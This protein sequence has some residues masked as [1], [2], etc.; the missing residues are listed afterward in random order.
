MENYL[1]IDGK[2]IEL[3][4][5]TADNIRSALKEPKSISFIPKVGIWIIGQDGGVDY[6]LEHPCR[7][8]RLADDNDGGFYFDDNGREEY[9]CTGVRSAT[10][11]E[12]ESHLKPICEEKY[13]GK[14]T[15]SVCDGHDAYPVKFGK[16]CINNDSLYYFD[17]DD[18]AIYVYH[19]GKFAEIIPDLKKLPE[20]KAEFKEFM[21]A[22]C[23]HA[24]N[25]YG[26]IDDFLYQYD[27]S[28]E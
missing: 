15:V 4:K 8:I 2:R 18:N 19:Q 14:K 6:S 3:S 26:Y 28:H 17:K 10:V 21:I 5:E 27:F 1:M 20:T 25:S 24:G 23:N 16:Y 13:V 9:E 12:I 11:Q 7:I 22:Y